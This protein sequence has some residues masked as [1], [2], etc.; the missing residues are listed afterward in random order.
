[1]ID[2]YGRVDLTRVCTDPSMADSPVAWLLGGSGEKIAELARK[3]SP[4]LHVSKDDPPFLIMHGDRDNVVPLWQSEAFAKA[5]REAGVE[6]NLIVLKGAGHGG[7]EFLEP[8]QIDTIT[9][10]LN[11]HFHV[12]APQS[13]RSLH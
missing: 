8:E 3:A 4:I 2:W 5:L 12:K 1:M 6:G 7:G 11:D 9:G 10:F 13:V